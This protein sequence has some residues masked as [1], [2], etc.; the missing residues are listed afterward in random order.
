MPKKIIIDGGYPLYGNVTVSGSKNATLPI[1]CAS[2]LSSGKVFLTNVPEIEDVRSLIKLLQIYNVDTK[3]HNNTLSLSVPEINENNYDDKALL[4]DINAYKKLRASVLLIGPLLTKYGKVIFK[5]PGGCKIGER[6]INLHL[7]GFEKMGAECKII[8]DDTIAVSSPGG[9][10][11]SN[12]YLNFPS[13]GATENL[14]M[15]SVLAEGSTIIKNVA[16]EPEIIDLA[17]FLNSMGTKIKGAGTDSIHVNGVDKLKEKITY[18]VIPDRLEAGTFISMGAI[19][20]G[21][22][23][24]EGADPTHLISILKAFQDAGVDLEVDKKYIY[25]HPSDLKSTNIVTGPYPAFPTDMQPMFTAMMTKAKGMSSI[26]E[27]IFTDRFDYISEL[28]KLGAKIQTISDSEIIVKG[29]T[30]LMGN[31][32]FARDIRGGAAILVVALAANGRSEIFNPAHIY[33][34]YE[35]LETKL[36]RLGTKIK[37]A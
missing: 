22:I 17:N 5:M 27:T 37:I 33:R 3:L 18:H 21:D 8:D 6:P 10:I 9:L 32:V 29:C 34:G 2:L 35:K 31:N 1:M 13:V 4:R 19:T 26:K 12:I 7:T 36:M 24:I 15:A 25:V 14:L 23:E 28:I 30:K 20:R 16:R 11:G